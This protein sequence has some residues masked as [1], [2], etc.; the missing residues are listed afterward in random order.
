MKTILVLTDFS[1]NAG[2]TAQYALKFAQ[3]I[4]ANLL[5]CNIYNAPAD[6]QKPGR[7]EWPLGIHEENS[8]EDLGALMSHLKSEID[9]GKE[10]DFR[11]EISQLSQEGSITDTINDIARLNHVYMAI[12]SMHSARTVSSFFSPDHAWE[13]I[14]HAN[15]PL[16]VI[17]YQVRFKNYQMIA[18]ATDLGVTDKYVLNA[19]VGLAKYT[20]A[21]VLVTHIAEIGSTLW[22]EEIK[23]EEFFNNEALKQNKPAIQYMAI[24]NKRL[25]PALI[26]LVNDTAIDMMVLVKRPHNTFQKIFGRNV[27]RRLVKHPAKPLLIFP[28]IEVPE[29]QLVF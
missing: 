12:I 27:I 3:K 2:Y 22:K 14:V 11:P 17:P 13:I 6:E 29:N 16:L 26:E 7:K 5:L 24:T 15:F 21:E 9:A 19:V 18:F 23:V 10:T 25:M 28:D 8:I 1:I 4:Q 20:D